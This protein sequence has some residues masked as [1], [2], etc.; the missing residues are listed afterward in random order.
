LFCFNLLEYIDVDFEL[1][2]DEINARWRE[3]AAVDQWSQMII[4]ETSSDVV[5]PTPHPRRS[6]SR[7]RELC[8]AGVPH[9]CSRSYS[10]RYSQDR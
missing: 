5:L 10:H 2:I 3:L 8:S 7:P 6:Q 9:T 1:D 4:K